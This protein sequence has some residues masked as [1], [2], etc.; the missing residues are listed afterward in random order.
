MTSGLGVDMGPWKC[1]H[2]RHLTPTS[3]ISKHAGFKRYGADIVASS[4]WAAQPTA[5]LPNCPETLVAKQTHED[6]DPGAHQEDMATTRM[7]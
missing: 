2:Q 7:K 4:V 1:S 3:S 6:V 5:Q